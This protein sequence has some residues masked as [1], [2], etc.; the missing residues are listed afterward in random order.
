MRKVPWEQHLRKGAELWG[1][2]LRREIIKGGVSRDGVGK[3]R[4]RGSLLQMTHTNL[5]I[6]Q[7]QQGWK[8][9]IGL[10]HTHLGEQGA[11]LRGVWL[12][13]LPS[14][15]TALTSRV[16]VCMIVGVFFS[17]VEHPDCSE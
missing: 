9:V 12:Q 16:F 10:S 4:W 3:A 2:G 14:P 5:C 8:G 13:S 7:K 17:S 11:L 1:E 6:P 15:T